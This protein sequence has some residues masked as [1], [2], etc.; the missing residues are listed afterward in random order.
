MK[1]VISKLRKLKTVNILSASIILVI[2]C[3]CT[4]GKFY[5]KQ[6][7][8][9]DFRPYNDKGFLMST[10]VI[11]EKYETI[12]EISIKCNSGYI[13]NEKKLQ[14]YSGNT[15]PVMTINQK[16]PKQDW[17]VNEVLDELY[18][19]AKSLG[20]NGVINIKLTSEQVLTFTDFEITGLA[21]KID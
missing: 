10:T 16:T 3:S 8:F 12:G 1:K 5:G 4:S 9:L 21:I 19:E 6:V 15:T 13:V 18:K 11:G 14:M 17:D 20:A 2:I 7:Y